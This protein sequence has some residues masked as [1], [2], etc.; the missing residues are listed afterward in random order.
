[1]QL[2]VY[3]KGVECFNRYLKESFVVPLAA[4]LKSSRST[5]FSS[6]L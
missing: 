3:G 1:V 2:T 4:T 5:G 6:S